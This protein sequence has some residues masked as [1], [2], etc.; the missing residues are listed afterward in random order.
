MAVIATGERVILRD[1]VPSDLDRWIYWLT[2]GEW[3]KF[4]A[5][6]EKS[7]DV[8]EPEE[9]AKIREKFLERCS[10]E[11]PVP[12]PFALI[13]TPDGVPLGWHNRYG[14][15]N[16]PEVCYV[17]IAIREDGWWNKGIGTESLRLWVDHQFANSEYHRIGLTT[18]SFNPA[19]MRVAEKV[20]F[21]HE[22]T[23]RDARKWEGRF[24]D[25]MEYG[26]LRSEWEAL[27]R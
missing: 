2:H 16:N 1:R 4:D 20:G 7:P 23:L 8:L 18:W 27:R 10:L 19:M 5:P 3:R 14:E 6:W 21:V 11:L 13:A 25:C 24:H 17:G 15:K 26:M 9:E 22:G 12:R